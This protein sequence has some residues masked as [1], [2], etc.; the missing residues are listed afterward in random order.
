M[1]EP[2]AP[3]IQAP[4][5]GSPSF[6]PSPIPGA[7]SPLTLDTPAPP[8]ERAGVGA[9][10]FA[11]KKQSGGLSAILT[12]GSG[13]DGAA[14]SAEPPPPRSGGVGV[15]MDSRGETPGVRTGHKSIAPSSAAS[16]TTEMTSA[17]RR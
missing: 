10:G 16:K 17:L 9:V 4:G 2:S 1:P 12:R 8:D 5:P 6:P 13:C 11:Q 3:G 14:F 15:M 7:E